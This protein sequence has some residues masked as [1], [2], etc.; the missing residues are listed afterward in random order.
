MQRLLTISVT[1]EGTTATL[2]SGDAICCYREKLKRGLYFVRWRK[3]TLSGAP[4]GDNSVATV[5]ALPGYY[6][7]AVG[8][9]RYRRQLIQ[10]YPSHWHCNGTPSAYSSASLILT[11]NSGLQSITSV[12]GR[13]L[14][15]FVLVTQPMLLQPTGLYWVAE[16]PPGAAPAIKFCCYS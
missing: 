14:H 1:R 7:T 3:R 10:L 2:Y 6:V 16:R 13:H 9:S 12:T 4:G 15:H 5:D 11:V 8:V